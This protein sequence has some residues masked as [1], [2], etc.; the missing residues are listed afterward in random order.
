MFFLKECINIVLKNN[1]ISNI[2]T[3][4]R[5]SW[6]KDLIKYLEN[7]FNKNNSNLKFNKNI[8]FF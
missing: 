6:L 1:N 7:Y 8:K 3:V 4:K 5:I 2:S